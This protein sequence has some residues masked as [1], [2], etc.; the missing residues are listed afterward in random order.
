MTYALSFS[1]DFLRDE[2]D[3]GSVAHMPKKRPTSV[4]QALANLSGKTWSRLAREIFRCE[5]KYLNIETVLQKVAETNTCLNL[6]SPV[7]VTIDP[8]GDFT[9]LVYDRDE[10]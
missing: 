1:P 8:N 6:D 4:A 10:P 5:P 7:E 9:V 3:N 2:A